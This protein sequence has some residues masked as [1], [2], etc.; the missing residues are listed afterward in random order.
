MNKKT[1]NLIEGIL[2]GAVFSFLISLHVA[3]FMQI[4]FLLRNLVINNWNFYKLLFFDINI[5]LFIMIWEIAIIT[6]VLAIYKE[7]F[8]RNYN[9]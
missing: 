2:I 7:K 8:S 1:S 4:V 9:F 3:L 6:A 5:I